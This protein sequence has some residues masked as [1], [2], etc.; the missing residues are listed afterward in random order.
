MT[1]PLILANNHKYTSLSGIK[2]LA[3]QTL[4]YGVSSIFARFLNYL[5]TPYLTGK[6]LGADYG[7]MS[8]VYAAVPFLNT[9]FLF[10]VETAFFRYIQKEQY[11]NEIYNTLSISIFSSTFFL[12][13]LLIIF[14][15]SF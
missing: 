5:L 7:E 9:L 12:T 14:N 4:W 3:G 15:K 10:G 8:L 13:T 2:K 6:L 11:K 1:E